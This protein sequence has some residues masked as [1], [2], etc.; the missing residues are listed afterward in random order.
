MGLSDTPTLTYKGLQIT[1]REWDE[2][3]SCSAIGKQHESL[4]KLKKAIDA[5]DR[6]VRK[7]SR[8]TLHQLDTIIPGIPNRAA[9]EQGGLG[10]RFRPVEIVEFLGVKNRWR[11][12][13]F[14]NI[15]VAAMPDGQSRRNM[16]LHQLVRD[17]PENQAVLDRANEVAG[18]IW[19]LLNRF[20]MILEELDYATEEDV[21][22][23]KEIHDRE[24]PDED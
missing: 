23:L 2:K 18:E 5:W 3:W 19:P 11:R 10:V 15:E 1:F 20:H 17:T 22:E 7:A 4:P 13:D 16:R 9:A 21:K 6:K 14:E 24:P 8:V 12:E